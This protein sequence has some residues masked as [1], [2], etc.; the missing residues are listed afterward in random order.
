MAHTKELESPT[1]WFV[2]RRSIQL[3]YAC[4]KKWRTW[5]V[6]I[7]RPDAWQASHLPLKVHVQKIYRLPLPALGTECS[8]KR[9][10]HS[11]R[12]SADQDLNLIGLIHN[13]RHYHICYPREMAETRGIE[14]RHPI[15]GDCFLAKRYIA[16]LSHLHKWSG[17][18]ESNSRHLL[19]RKV[20]YH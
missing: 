20:F 4:K 2:V 10:Q 19:G 11:T 18:R 7:S 16:T 8:C 17:M 6:L 1:F 9:Y 13:Q 12:K 14:P 3:S 15:K 5:R